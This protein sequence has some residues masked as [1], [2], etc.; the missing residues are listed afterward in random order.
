MVWVRIPSC[1]RSTQLRSQQKWKVYANTEEM[2]KRDKPLYS[3]IVYMHTALKTRLTCVNEVGF[4]RS[5][6]AI[7]MAWLG[8][9]LPPLNWF[10]TSNFGIY[11]YSSF[12]FHRPNS[13]NYIRSCETQ[14]QRLI[15]SNEKNGRGLELK[16]IFLFWFAAHQCCTKQCRQSYFNPQLSA[17]PTTMKVLRRWC[18]WINN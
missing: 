12:L 5:S 7:S 6:R 18:L 10:P 3:R 17:P 9:V 15:K 16:I 2:F 13:Q 4:Y 14:Q 1:G 11:V 8:A